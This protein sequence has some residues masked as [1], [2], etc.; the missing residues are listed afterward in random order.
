MPDE[1]SFDWGEVAFGSKKPINKL[2]ATFIAAPREMSADRFTQLVKKYLP[3]GN[4]V[5]GLAKESYVDGLDAQPQFT[6]L[7]L[8]AVSSVIKK[9]AASSSKYKVY[10]LSYF[11][12]E[13]NYILQKLSFQKV[14]FING[15]WHHSF[16]LQPMYYTLANRHVAY[17]LVSPFTDE[18]EARAYE[19]AADNK[20]ADDQPNLSIVSPLSDAAMLKLTQLIAKQSYDH[21][22]QTGVIIGKQIDGNYKFITS[23]YNKVVPYQTYA[24]HFGSLREKYFSPP[25]DLNHYD[26]IHAEVAMLINAQKQGLSLADTTLF[27]NVLPCPTCG[28]MLAETDITEVVYQLDHSDG[29]TLGVLERAGKKVRRIVV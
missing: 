19:R 16:H 9:I 13:T 20:L 7:Q 21:T 25:N 22:N 2:N 4:I 28:R 11:Q 6:M 1:Y 14:V 15:S 18:A 17:E 24:M 12:R 29:Y 5:L 27:I 26:T 8:D 23:A 3:E 10:T